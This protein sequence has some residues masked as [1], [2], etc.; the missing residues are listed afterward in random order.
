L[1]L[2]NSELVMGM[3]EGIASVARTKGRDA[4]VEYLFEQILARRCSDNER[5][6]VGELIDVLDQPLP[7]VP[8]NQWSYGTAT[9]EPESG[10]IEA[11]RLLPRFH[12]DRWQGTSDQL[13]DPELDWASLSAAGGHPGTR[14]DQAVVRRWTS[15]SASIV[16]VRGALKHPSDQGN[17]VRGTIILRGSEKAGQWTAVHGETET[18]IDE[19]SVQPGDT[20]DFVTDCLGDISNDSFEW[21]VRVVSNDESRVRANSERHFSSH[22][23]GVLNVWEQVAQALLLTNE[24]CFID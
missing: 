6:W 16:R 20:I 18:S 1:V 9:L 4:G 12:S 22:Q 10:R 11:F 7:T 19:I 13:P 17:G 21:K 24:F 3:L 2:F 23:P 5:A 15:M 14:A 8:E